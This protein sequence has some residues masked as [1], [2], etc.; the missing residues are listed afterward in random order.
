MAGQFKNR[1]LKS[2]LLQTGARNKWMLSG[3]YSEKRKDL[4]EHEFTAAAISFHFASDNPSI[5][6]NIQWL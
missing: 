2:H 4:H 6:L 3:G 5:F 1:K